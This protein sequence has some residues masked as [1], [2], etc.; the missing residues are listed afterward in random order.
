MLIIDFSLILFILVL[1]I[2]TV[3]DSITSGGIYPCM[4]ILV[5]NIDNRWGS[6]SPACFKCSDDKL[7]MPI[8]IINKDLI[9]RYAAKGELS[10]WGSSRVTSRHLLV[11]TYY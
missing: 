4:N 9:T 3:T 5:N 10:L 2:G 7:S 6:I 8:K 1:T 11:I